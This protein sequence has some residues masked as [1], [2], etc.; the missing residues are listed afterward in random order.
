MSSHMSNCMCMTNDSRNDI[1]NGMSNKI[2]MSKSI[3]KGFSIAT[4]IPNGT[5]MLNSIN[6][7][8]FT[9]IDH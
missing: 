2:C 1:S 5:C 8:V 3:N 7:A 6:N 4:Y 9:P